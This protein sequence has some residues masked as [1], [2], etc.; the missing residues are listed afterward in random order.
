MK[1]GE[2]A[3]GLAAECPAICNFLN[4]SGGSELAALLQLDLNVILQT[5]VLFMSVTGI[6]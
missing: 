3:L 1:M 6:L 4:G 2:N 5:F